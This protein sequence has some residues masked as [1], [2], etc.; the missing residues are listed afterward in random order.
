M[1]EKKVSFFKVIINHYR[2]PLT[3][4]DRIVPKPQ[5]FPKCNQLFV[6][7]KMVVHCISSP[8]LQDICKKSHENTK[9]TFLKISFVTNMNLHFPSCTVYWLSP[10][11]QR[12]RVT[13][14]INVANSF[15]V[16]YFSN[17]PLLLIRD[18]CNATLP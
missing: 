12:S 10:Q 6:L 7:P 14:A 1:F 15:I 8:I 13:L 5:R 18:R 4:F 16:F 17:L 11:L 9:T 2:K 3:L